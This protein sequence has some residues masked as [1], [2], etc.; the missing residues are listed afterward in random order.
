MASPS[1]MILTYIRSFYSRNS[2]NSKA[3]KTTQTFYYS[4]EETQSAR[5]SKSSSIVSRSHRGS[6]ASRGSFDVDDGS[7]QNRN[8]LDAT[9]PSTG[10]VV[11]AIPQRRES[12]LY[13]SDSE[14]E[15][16]PK[17]MSRHSS[18]G[19][20]SNRRCHSV[21]SKR[22]I[23]QLCNT[24]EPSYSDCVKGVGGASSTTLGARSTV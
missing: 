1:K 3:D 22:P 10:L 20:E 18:L 5:T 21:T 14:F 15:M 11:H 24:F 6:H 23:G 13:R 19:S 9:S 8:L 17:S 16:S 12:F 7:G 4:F 2:V